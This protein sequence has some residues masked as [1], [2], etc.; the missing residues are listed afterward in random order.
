MNYSNL[1]VVLICQLTIVIQ[2]KLIETNQVGNTL[3][4][5]GSVVQY[6]L[7]INLY[8][9][10]EF[11]SMTTWKVFCE[12]LGSVI[13]F[14]PNAFHFKPTGMIYTPMVWCN[15]AE[16]TTQTYLLLICCPDKHTALLNDSSST[17]NL[18]PCTPLLADSKQQKDTERSLRAEAS[19]FITRRLV[20]ISVTALR[21][22]IQ[23]L[24]L[25]PRWL[26]TNLADDTT[27]VE[28]IYETLKLCL[29]HTTKF[30]DKHN[31]VP[32]CV[33]ELVQTV[34]WHSTTGIWVLYPLS[35]VNIR[36]YRRSRMFDK[37]MSVI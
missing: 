14:R 26:A 8:P 22:N 9:H 35:Y 4:T 18:K 24:Q 23:A 21:D 20:A 15:P 2:V 7:M 19:F 13:L 27:S 33:T 25:L 10:E 37:E 1:L 34:R 16:W 17:G 5:D 28:P 31:P 12:I 36:A 32:V 30:S 11:W 3:Q 29:Y 6:S